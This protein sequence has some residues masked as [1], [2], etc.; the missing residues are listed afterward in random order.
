ML[1]HF[2]NCQQ[3]EKGKASTE[4]GQNR[5]TQPSA[6]ETHVLRAACASDAILH[7]DPCEIN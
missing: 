1:V 7:Q 3:K 5:S 2:T 6:R 4:L